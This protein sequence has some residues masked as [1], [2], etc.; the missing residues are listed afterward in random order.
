MARRPR[1]LGDQCDL[2]DHPGHVGPDHDACAL[3][4][5]H[6]AGA[7]LELVHC[8][9]VSTHQ[10]ASMILDGCPL[11]R[12]QQALGHRVGHHDGAADGHDATSA[13]CVGADERLEQRLLALAAV[14]EQVALDVMGSRADQRVHE[15]A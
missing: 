11:Q 15:R 13:S 6:L 12:R 2:Q 5:D 10:V 4:P 9:L 14:Y 1:G 8:A 7:Q 3:D